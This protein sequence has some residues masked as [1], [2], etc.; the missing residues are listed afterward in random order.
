METFIKLDK[1][2]INTRRLGNNI[3][4]KVD[5]KFSLIFTPEALEELI[6]DY[7]NISETEIT[8]NKKNPLKSK[9]V[10]HSSRVLKEGEKVAK[11]RTIPV[12]P[13]KDTEKLNEGVS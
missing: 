1:K 13:I 6:N 10:P 5:E 7:S 12:V 3:E 2:D 9:P 11:P 4:I 8:D